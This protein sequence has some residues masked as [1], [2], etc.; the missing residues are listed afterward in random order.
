VNITI[1]NTPT[2]EQAQS[3]RT[4][5]ER[6]SDPALYRMAAVAFR[7]LDMPSAAEAM[8]RRADHYEATI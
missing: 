2:I 4:I 5:A 1:P 3:L 6:G 7:L 8:Q